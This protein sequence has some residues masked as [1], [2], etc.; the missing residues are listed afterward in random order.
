MLMHT[1]AASITA[2][3]YAH[4]RVIPSA[5]ALTD[6]RFLR[7]AQIMRGGVLVC[8]VQI[9]LLGG[10]QRAA[11]YMVEFLRGQVRRACRLLLLSLSVIPGPFCFRDVQSARGVVLLLLE[12]LNGV[13]TCGGALAALASTLVLL[14]VA[15]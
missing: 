14:I 3:R 7:C 15:L 9:Y 4:A 11:Q 13:V 12:L 6:H 1:F 10:E 5:P 8:T 2:S